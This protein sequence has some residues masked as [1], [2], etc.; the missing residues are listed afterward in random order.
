MNTKKHIPNEALLYFSRL[1]PRTPPI[2]YTFY[3]VRCRHTRRTYIG[4]TKKFS[5]RKEQHI[6]KLRAGR[7]ESREMQ[8]DFDKFGE[9]SF[10]FKPVCKGGDR[11]LEIK[12]IARL[13]KKTQL[14][15]ALIP[16]RLISQLKY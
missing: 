2:C 10:L 4:R 8:A 1:F 14:Y 15:N 12:L 13:M 11:N 6:W 7:H 3:V 5:R 16:R 9:D